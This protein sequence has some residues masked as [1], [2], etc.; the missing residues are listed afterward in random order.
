M[1]QPK[2]KIGLIPSPPVGELRV[3][4]TEDGK[5]RVEC[6]FAEGN[7]WL[8]Q[9]LIAQLFDKD[10]RTVNDH[11]LNIYEEAEL[12]PQATIRKYRIVRSEG[13]RQ[14]A[15]QIDHYNLDAILAVGY[16]VRSVQGTQFRRWA[17]ERL[18]EFL[19]K[20]FTL[21]DERLKNPPA[22]GS[23][24]GDYF[25]ELLER[26]RDIRASEK[27]MYLRVRE[28]FALAA[29]YQP[30]QRQT[31]EFFSHIQNKL[32]YASTGR[33]AAELIA[34]RADHGQRDSLVSFLRALD[35]SPMEWEEAVALTG[36]PSPYIGDVLSAGFSKAS[37]LVVLMTP[38][39]EVRLKGHLCRDDE[40]ASEREIRGQS[41]PN[42]IFEAGMALGQFSNRTILVGIGNPKPFSDT[43]GRHVLKLDNTPERRTALAAKL[44]T[45][46]CIINNT[47]SDWLRIGDFKLQES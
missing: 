34:E 23:G 43:L 21:D 14:V 18:R 5:V 41:R 13:G 35:L 2:K 32:H 22:A 26:I 30:D 31:G 11:L 24:F 10:V 3:Y 46:G 7:L 29:D 1:P 12:T 33:T 44:R 36:Q 17:T 8:T 42:V 19:V 40:P 15:R 6:R 25:D 38:D 47:G 16:R 4:T 20:G 27:R 28:I 45:A 37:A 39:D 9:A